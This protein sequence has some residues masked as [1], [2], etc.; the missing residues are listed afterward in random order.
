MAVNEVHYRLLR[1]RRIHHWLHVS[2]NHRDGSGR[3]LDLN[4]FSFQCH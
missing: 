3:I 2:F 1:L 4:C